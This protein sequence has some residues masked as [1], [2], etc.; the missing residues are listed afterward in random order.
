MLLVFVIFMLTSFKRYIMAAVALPRLSSFGLGVH[1]CSSTAG[2]F[3]FSLKKGSSFCIEIGVTEHAHGT[4]QHRRRAL[5]PSLRETPSYI[6]NCAAA[7]PLSGRVETVPAS[8][9]AQPM[10]MMQSFDWT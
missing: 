1:N 8:Q 10:Q 4:D 3:F 5:C 9:Q 7:Q 6:Q 2:T